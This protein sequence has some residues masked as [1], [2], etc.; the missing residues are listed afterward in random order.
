MVE[1]EQNSPVRFFEL[2]D[3]VRR[4]WRNISP[5]PE[6]SKSQFATLMVLKHAGKPPLAQFTEEEVDRG[7]SLSA[8]AGVMGQS[9][10]AVSQ[11]I[12]ALEA[13]GY[14]ERVADPRD[15]RVSGVRLS[16]GGKALLAE[17]YQHMSKM[18]DEAMRAVGEE[19]IAMMMALL[20]QMATRL[21]E[22][23]RAQA[24]TENRGRV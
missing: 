15:R 23:G 22:M 14:V 24:Q 21:E 19:N 8:L 4:A 6:L 9:L 12:S 17:A 1:Q 10:P 20:E 5:C 3:R 13:M 16:E 2:M 7:L 11:R 18:M